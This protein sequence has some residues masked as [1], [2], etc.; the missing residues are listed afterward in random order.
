MWC[1]LK[2]SI[3]T[4]S[5]LCSSSL[6]AASFSS[7]SLKCRC[8]KNDG[9]IMA[10]SMYR[11]RSSP[12]KNIRNPW[13]VAKGTQ[14]QCNSSS[15]QQKK[16]TKMKSSNG[17]AHI[18][19]SAKWSV[20]SVSIVC[21]SLLA[22]AFCNATGFGHGHWLS[23]Y[24][25]SNKHCCC[26]LHSIFVHIFIVC[27]VLAFEKP[28]VVYLLLRFIFFRSFKCTWS[29]WRMV[30]SDQARYQAH[31]LLFRFVVILRMMHPTWNGRAIDARD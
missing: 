13:K 17:I 14:L 23:V 8:I 12:S 25:S 27:A 7:A 19:L 5:D 26:A 30:R 9:A 28:H 10:W 18:I 20:F 4:C 11:C 31:E 16:T 1:C 29:V 21:F 2:T 3:M 6:F 15:K 22:V 24:N